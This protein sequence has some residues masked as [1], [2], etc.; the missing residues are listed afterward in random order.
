[1]SITS[2]TQII[3]I[4]NELKA[5]QKELASKLEN[6]FD[7]LQKDITDLKVAMAKLESTVSDVQELKST[8][9]SQVWALIS[10]LGVAVVGTV[11]REFITTP[12]L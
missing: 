7:G 8:Q 1:M 4:L 9:K 3:D 10:L 6:K 2:D 11:I 12:K 5:S